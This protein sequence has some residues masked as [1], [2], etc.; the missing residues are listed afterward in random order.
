[1][2]VFISHA[3]GEDTYLQRVLSRY[4]AAHGFCVWDPAE[5][6]RGLDS[7][8]TGGADL[9]DL[10]DAFG[11]AGCPMP[12]GFEAADPRMREL[13][14]TAIGMQDLVVVLWSR[15]HAFRYWTAVERTTAVAMGKPVL[16]LRV[17]ATPMPEDLRG[18]VDRGAI[19]TIGVSEYLADAGVLSRALSALADASGGRRV[20]ATPAFD[21]SIGAEFVKLEDTVFGELELGRYPLTNAQVERC[22]PAHADR[23][24]GRS[25]AD[26]EP[27]VLVNWNEARQFCRDLTDRS[28][29]AEYRLPSE[30]EWEYGARAGDASY[31]GYDAG[32]IGRGL[33]RSARVGTVHR[34]RWGLG[35]FVGN[36]GQWTREISRW[37]EWNGW[38]RPAL[39]VPIN[40]EPS[41]FHTVKGADWSLQERLGPRSLSEAAACPSLLREEAVGLRLVR[42]ARPGQAVRGHSE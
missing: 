31:L 39:P 32:R 16:V 15:H 26:D 4:L 21:E 36:V 14:V 41:D 33:T 8:P 24:C 7:V 11:R 27:A 25:A 30:V 20:R 10:R 2:Q 35:D 42:Q 23:R 12:A 37:R 40:G 19:P 18:A 9:H 6:R 22:W 3:F 17:D 1:M 34:N 29:T 28:A 5:L 13:L 38:Y